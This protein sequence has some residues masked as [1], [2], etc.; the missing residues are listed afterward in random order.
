MIATLLYEFLLYFLALFMLPK[1][2]WSAYRYGKYH[3]AVMQRLGFGPP[4]YTNLSPQGSIWI[5]AVS[6]GEMKAAVPLIKELIR[7]FPTHPLVISNTTET[8]HQ[9][10]LKNVP[11]ASA[12]VY[13]PFDFYRSVSKAL[14]AARPA[15]VIFCETDFWWNFLRLSKQQGAVVALVNGKLSARSANRLNMFGRFGTFLFSWF[16]VGCVQN[17]IYLERFLRAGAPPERFFITGNLKFDQPIPPELSPPERALARQ[18]LNIQ[19]GAQV[20]LIVST[21]DPEETAFLPILIDLWKE[22][23]HL[24]VVLAP[25]HPE[26]TSDVCSQLERALIPFSRYSQATGDQR[27]LLLVD[28]IGVLH[29]FYSIAD[30]AVVGGSFFQG[31][32]GHNILEPCSY[33][34][35][36]LFGPFMESQP[37]LLA[38]A[39]EQHMGTQ[40]TLSEIKNEICSLL[41]NPSECTKRG[42]RAKTS[43]AA[44][45]GS[46]AQTMQ[47]LAPHLGVFRNPSVQECSNFS[48]NDDITVA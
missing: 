7:R 33:A 8:G 41:H 19:K 20:L 42:K 36:V 44:L 28:Q 22:F 10:A 37:E 31:V 34:L 3:N 2:A 23:P 12:H 4:P 24:K 29:Q 43:L 48:S 1:M 27:P 18:R 39:Q 14:R 21:H 38:I 13:L 47:T 16:D 30:I 6:V 17:S 32:G 40:V 45:S 35:P 15:L 11:E 46:L 26:R 5:H 25:R 9:E